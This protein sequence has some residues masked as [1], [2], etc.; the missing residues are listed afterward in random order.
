MEEEDAEEKEIVVI[1]FTEQK[2]DS[3]NDENNINLRW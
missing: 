1:E 3:G 2:A